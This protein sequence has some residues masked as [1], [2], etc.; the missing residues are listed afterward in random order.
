MQ[1]SV[2]RRTNT[3]SVGRTIDQAGSKLVN[4]YFDSLV[5]R[6]PR[7]N[8]RA[9]FDSLMRSSADSSLQFLGDMF[10]SKLC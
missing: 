6:M 10:D 4:S 5:A 1:I 9:I 8:Q 7:S 3:E 2:S